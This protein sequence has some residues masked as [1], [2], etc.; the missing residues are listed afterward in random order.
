[1]IGGVANDNGPNGTVL[2]V[3][4]VLN[5]VRAIDRV[6]RELAAGLP[7]HLPVDIVVADG[8]SSDGT[9][10][11][12]AAIAARD[13]R[14]RLMPNPRRLQGAAVNLVARSRADA[15]WLVR[16]DAHTAYPPGYVADLVATLQRTGADAVVVPMDSRGQTCMA[17]AIAWVSDT[18]LGSGGSAHRGGRHAGWIDHGHHA[19]WRMAS[20]LAAGGYD[21]SF[22]HNEDAELDC[23]LARWG[24][25][26]WMEP[27][28]RLTYFVRPTLPA[29]WRQYRNYGRGR[30]RTV[31]RHPSSLRVRQVLV[32]TGVAAI[33]LATLGAPFRPELWLVPASYVVVLSATSILLALRHR[34]RCALGSGLAALVMHFGWATG[35]VTGLL[36]AREPRPA[37]L[38]GETTA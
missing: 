37:A 28:I 7:D 32:P 18:P 12:V 25:R 21:E 9:Q 1:M 34:S 29:L 38:G 35:F 16:A 30:S 14:V 22:T 3:V 26:I 8:G 27:A 33:V 17:R 15:Q 31:R 24:G 36:A 13:P 4:P 23:R 6:L 20:Y 2:I 19:A 10:A 5:E 11:R